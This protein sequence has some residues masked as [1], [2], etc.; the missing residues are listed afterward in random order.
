MATSHIN[1]KNIYLNRASPYITFPKCQIFLR[2]PVKYEFTI[3]IFDT[4]SLIPANRNT[5]LIKIQDL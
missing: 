5:I 3:Y 4:F 2:T 1:G